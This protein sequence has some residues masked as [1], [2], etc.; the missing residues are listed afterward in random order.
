MPEVT[1]DD[2]IS[3]KLKYI[4]LELENIPEFLTN[5]S[6]IDYRPLKAY[7]ENT[8]RVYKYIPISKIKILLTPMNRLNTI[9]EKY[10]KATNLK[11]YLKPETEDDII[12]HTTFLK[13][14]KS[15]KIEEIE[16]LVKEQENLNK[17]IPFKVKFEEN[18]LWQIHYSD[19]D[20][21]YFML[22][23][24]EDLEY[25]SLFYL[26]KKQVECYKTKK[27]Q[28]IYVPIAYENYSN[29][30]LKNSEIS[31]IEKYLWFF[32]K[33]WSNIYDVYDKKENL[34]IHIVGQT[35]IYDNIKCIYKNNLNSKED[36]LKFYKF[37]KAL[38]I[39]NTELP[40][41]YKFEINLD[42]YG[43]LEF[44]YKNEKISYDNMFKLFA[45]D[46]SKAKDKIIALDKVNVELEQK[47]NELKNISYKK[48]QEY[49]LKEKQIAT[50]LECKKT[51]LGRVKYFLKSRKK[52]KQK[53][54]DDIE[55][56]QNQFDK[57]DKKN[58]IE[59][60]LKDFYTVEDI[61]K[62]YKQLNI[63]DTNVKN[64]K[65]DE[66]ALTD[67]IKNIE[68]KIKNA[69]LY[70]EEI[71]K[72]EKSIF[73]FWKFANKD[74]KLML[75][76]A[77]EAENINQNKIE[78][79]YN[80][81]EDKE[82]IGDFIDKTQRNILSK[83]ETDAIY[84]T[85][86]SCIEALNNI[87]NDSVLKNNLSNLKIELQQQRV[88]FEKDKIDIFGGISDDSDKVKMIKGKKHREVPK[89][90]LRILDITKD[91][92]LEEYRNNLIQMSKDIKYA[93]KQSKHLIGISVYISVSKEEDFKKL[94]IC[95]L[96]IEDVINESK[97]EEV[98]IY[99]INLKED[100]KVIYFSN[101]IYYDNYHKTL[102]IGMN[103][104]EKCLIDMDMYKLKLIKEDEFRISRLINEFKIST[105]KV[106]V[107]E[108]ELE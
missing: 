87:E 99:K 25:A 58:I 46:Y 86:T 61:I 54:E 60:E 8:Y 18:Y 81:A 34:S 11:P 91:T 36:A 19:I 106:L 105:K 98:N 83:K 39:L 85:T 37:L 77:T 22:V 53:E 92:S 96:N 2:E 24:T 44:R 104:T 57:E 79:V 43:S 31:D 74:E 6:N 10:S 108:F 94:Q 33:N 5:S 67:K 32:T 7:D 69:S 12:L 76:S 28:M 20:D 55:S 15:V 45:Q 30:F 56:T 103:V 70:I 66:K 93:L 59:Y 50:Y 47:I 3:K 42:R 64:L 17:E 88:L 40:H 29:E 65:M 73:E 107:K 41:D 4:G 90:K 13:M 100:S 48:E 26:L 9:K 95:N 35:V 97:K 16:K 1:N 84:I 27:E 49:F 52:K 21:V 78:K 62:I 75:S 102:P 23:P 82:E 72:H 101:I 71:D 89:D 14:L 38:F 80:Y 63:I 68:T 51:F